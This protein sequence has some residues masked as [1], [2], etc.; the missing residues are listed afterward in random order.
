[1]GNSWTPTQTDCNVYCGGDSSQTCG[2][3]KVFNIFEAKTKGTLPPP[4]TPT[5]I[6]T[7]GSSTTT[8]FITAKTASTAKSSASAATPTW[9]ALGCYKDL[10]PSSNRTLKNIRYTSDSNVTI[11]GCQAFCKKDGYLYTGIENGRECWCGNEVQSPKTNAPVAEVDCKKTCID[12]RTLLCG[13]IAR[14]YLH[15]YI[16]PV[17]PWIGLGCYGEES[18]R[19][20]RNQVTVT[21]G[22]GNN[23]RQN[24]IDGC[25]RAGYPY[26]G[27]QDTREC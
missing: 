7:L 21:G 8:V 6:T 11:V 14:V 2:G 9:Q 20:L 12:D 26:A 23:T 5:S 18:P 24:C 25:D 1:V 10:Y 17:V 4:S 15:M 16:V 19:I 27:V 3:A 22:T 13:G